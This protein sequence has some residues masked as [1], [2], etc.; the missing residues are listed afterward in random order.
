MTDGRLQIIWKWRQ[1]ISVVR[2]RLDSAIE[3]LLMGYAAKRANLRL[4]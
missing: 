1:G 4:I 2:R 3:N